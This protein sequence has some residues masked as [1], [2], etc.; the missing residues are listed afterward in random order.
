MGKFLMFIGGVCC[1]FVVEALIVADS[2]KEIGKKDYDYGRTVGRLEADN[3]CMREMIWGYR[4]GFP[5]LRD[6]HCDDT[7]ETEETKEEA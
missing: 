2:L 1:G 6:W 7:E 3:I 4:K 5:N